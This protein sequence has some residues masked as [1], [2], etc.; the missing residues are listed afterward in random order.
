MVKLGK[1]PCNDFG[2]ITFDNVDPGVNRY[3]L[4]Y[5][6]MVKALACRVKG[7]GSNLTWEK[8][9]KKFREKKKKKKKGQ[10]SSDCTDGSPDDGSAPQLVKRLG[11]VLS[12]LYD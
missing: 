4:R 12:C 7:P 5:G 1:D 3:R 6:R 8:F 10:L 2:R 9:R 11:C